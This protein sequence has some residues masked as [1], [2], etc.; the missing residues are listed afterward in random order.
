MSR[1][2]VMIDGQTCADTLK[3]FGCERQAAW[4]RSADA[5]LKRL[6]ADYARLRAEADALHERLQQYEPTPKAYES[7]V[8]WTGD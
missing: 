8:R 6:A 7:P 4:C 2:P 5:N 3:Q 1:E